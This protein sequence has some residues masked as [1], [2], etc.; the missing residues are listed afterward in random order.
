M[1]DPRYPVAQDESLL[2][3]H[4]ALYACVQ[5]S[6]RVMTRYMEERGLTPSQFD[7]LATLGDTEGMTFK[8]LSQRSMV[9]GGTL[10]P[11]LNRMELKGLVARCKG[12][13]DNRQTIVRLTPE[14][15]ALYEKT[16]LPFIDYARSYLDHLTPDE[17]AQLTLLLNK[18]AYAYSEET[19][20][21]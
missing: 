5:Q 7:A 4:R 15:Q 2:P 19:S 17:Q 20:H 10:T 13:T 3:V 9:T 16:F 1:R 18:L 8:E 14:G 11:V 6:G 21:V 12:E